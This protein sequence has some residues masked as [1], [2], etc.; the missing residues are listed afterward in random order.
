MR[1]G[2]HALPHASSATCLVPSLRVRCLRAGGAILDGHLQTLA[3]ACPP[4]NKLVEVLDMHKVFMLHKLQLRRKYLTSLLGYLLYVCL[5]LWLSVYVMV[6]CYSMVPDDLLNQLSSNRMRCATNALAIALQKWQPSSA[7]LLRERQALRDFIMDEPFSVN[8]SDLVYKKT[9]EHVATPEEFWQWS[10]GPLLGSFFTN[11]S[12]DLPSPLLFSNVLIGTIRL[13]QVR[14]RPESC[15]SDSDSD[16]EHDL[17]GLAAA[18]SSLQCYQQFEQGVTED[19]KAFG[20]RQQY[21]YAVHGSSIK[22]SPTFA[23]VGLKSGAWSKPP[24]RDNSCGDQPLTGVPC[25]RPGPRR[26]RPAHIELRRRRICCES[27]PIQNWCH[28]DAGANGGGLY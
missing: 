28:A 21:A 20:L 23:S 14:S 24:I 19:T 15:R 27:A 18:S 13:R 16:S 7:M 1:T 11:S 6:R 8:A 2:S 4:E 12:S 25:L 22:G 26:D 3:A 9:S 10:Y 5:L 17:R